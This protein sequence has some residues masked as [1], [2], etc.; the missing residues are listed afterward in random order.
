MSLHCATKSEAEKQ[1]EWSES[2]VKPETKAKPPRYDRR[3][4]HYKEDD[5]DLSMKEEKKDLKRSNHI[6]LEQAIVRLAMRHRG[7]DPTY[8]DVRAICAS[9]GDMDVTDPAE[10]PRLASATFN[11][12]DS[13]YKQARYVRVLPNEDGTGFKQGPALPDRRMDDATWPVWPQRP[14]L[15]DRDLSE[16]DCRDLVVVARKLLDRKRLKENRDAAFRKALDEAIWTHDNGKFQAKVDAPT[17]LVLLNTLAS[18]KY[19]LTREVYVPTEVNEQKRSEQM[20][21]DPTQYW[22]RPADSHIDPGVT[23][24]EKWR[25]LF[26]DGGAQ[27]YD[28]DEPYMEHFVNPTI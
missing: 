2:R 24:D 8:G 27:Q 23:K 10:W 28:D 4:K 11:V 7:V 13:T 20:P 1:D 21:F 14:E 9:V 26:E 6:A 16:A 17:Y 19:D 18:A 25:K 5:P 3:R 15:M 12:L 22:G